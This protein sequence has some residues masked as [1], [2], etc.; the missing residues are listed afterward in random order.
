MTAFFHFFCFKTLLFRQAVKTRLPAKKPKWKIRPKNTLLAITQNTEMYSQYKPSRKVHMRWGQISA[1]CL[2][3]WKR[4]DAKIPW[5]SMIKTPNPNYGSFDVWKQ[6]PQRKGGE[7]SSLYHI[8]GFWKRK[9]SIIGLAPISTQRRSPTLKNFALVVMMKR[10]LMTFDEID[11][12]EA[13]I[14]ELPR[15]ASKSEWRTEGQAKLPEYVFWGFSAPSII[16][17]NGAFRRGPH[18]LNILIVL[19]KAKPQKIT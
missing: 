3:S 17:L 14:N 10:E 7:L 19:E 16:S 18:A 5:W 11:S 13:F 1:N 8:N 15:E 6:Q 9:N 4:C 12:S 2:T